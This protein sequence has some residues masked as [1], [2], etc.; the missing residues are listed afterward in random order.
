MYPGNKAPARRLAG[1]LSAWFL[2]GSLLAGA[3]VAAALPP[4]HEVQ[5][6]M[7]AVQESVEGERW[8]EAAE[9]LNRLQRID[10]S[11]PPGYLFY[12]GQV[13][14]RSEHYNEALSALENYVAGTGADGTHYTEALKLITDIE[15]VRA[16]SSAG[17]PD[18][19]GEPVAEIRPVKG[20]ETQRLRRLYM[21]NSE[22]EALVMHLNSLLE[23]AGWR[24]DARVIRER[25]TPDIHYQVS[26]DNGEIRFREIRVGDGGNRSL[27]T[28]PLRVY[29][30][31]PAIEWNCEEATESCWIYDPR[32]NAR[33]LQLGS[34][35]DK[36]GEIAK[37]LGRL[38]RHMQQPSGQS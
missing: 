21:V 19:P 8:G 30:I 4:E 35:R 6:L 26:V 14:A 33:F 9:Y 23:L 12:R 3:S 34:D 5:R 27:T 38:I 36:A 15:K 17:V 11:K 37:T 13:M 31:S 2:A 22:R 25:S 24:E 7:L 1:R 29:G 20:E 28:H 18:G 32:D 16:D 10:A